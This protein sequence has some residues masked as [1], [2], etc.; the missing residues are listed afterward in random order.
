MMLAENPTALGRIRQRLRVLAALIIR[1]TS[2]R[3]GRSWGGYIWAIAEP[4]GGIVLLSVAFSLITLACYQ[5]SLFVGAAYERLA[6]MA[7][8]GTLS[9]SLR[10]EADGG[11]RRTSERTVRDV[12]GR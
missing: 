6:L 8:V 12:V 10:P 4:T 11:A 5:V 9:V 3:F 7:S 1:E 2:A